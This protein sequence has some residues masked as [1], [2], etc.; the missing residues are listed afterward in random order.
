MNRGCVDASNARPDVTQGRHAERPWAAWAARPQHECAFCAQRRQRA[1]ERRS[2][3]AAEQLCV[4]Q[5]APSAPAA[6]RLVTRTQPR[7]APALAHP[8][9]G[10][11]IHWRPLRCC[12]EPGGSS[13]PASGSWSTRGKDK[14]RGASS[15]R[16]AMLDFSK[17]L[18]VPQLSMLDLRRLFMLVPLMGSTSGRLSFAR[19]LMCACH[20]RIPTQCAWRAPC[21]E[22]PRRSASHRSCCYLATAVAGLCMPLTCQPDRRL[23]AAKQ[24]AAPARLAQPVQLQNLSVPTQHLMPVLLLRIVGAG[25]S[26]G[27]RP[28]S[29]AGR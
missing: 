25:T 17:Q 6:Q 27:R 9:N 11:A 24:Q 18:K 19:C 5:A 2:P 8:S 13:L 28:P 20:W 12:G 14:G 7:H 29:K 10:Q 23:V 15:Q 3:C 16:R 4:P 22:G 1:L 21:I 26:H